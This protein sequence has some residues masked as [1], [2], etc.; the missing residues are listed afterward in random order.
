MV[1]VAVDYIPITPKGFRL[2]YIYIVLF[3]LG[4]LQ[5]M[6]YCCVLILAQPYILR[7]CQ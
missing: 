4:D 1:L 3:L 6:H 7:K 2:V 5:Q